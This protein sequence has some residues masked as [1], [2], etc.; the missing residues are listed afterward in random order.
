MLTSEDSAVANSNLAR[1]LDEI[2][3]RLVEARATASPLPG[4]PGPLPEELEHAYSVQSASI[5]RWPD[6]VAGW[7]V[8]GVPPSFRERMGVGRLAGPIF[9]GS[10]ASV[11]SGDEVSMPIFDGGFAAIEAE[12]VFRIGETIEPTQSDLSN[13]E[14]VQRI[15]ALHIGAEVASSPMADINR[16]GPCSIVSDFG[17][18]AGLVVGPEVDDWFGLPP[19]EMS[20]RVTLDGTVV[21]SAD[22][23]AVDG[24]LLQSLRFLVTLC[25]QRDLALP[26]GTLV[27]CGAMTG[28]HEV[29]V[30]SSA[31]I[32]FGASGSFTVNFVAMQ[33][34]R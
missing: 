14:L 9:Q 32:D 5:A 26:S 31:T 13:E 34:R 1:E 12:Y 24:G 33:P 4:F 27:S 15:A 29:S 22:A 3:T 25:A 17:N 10:I 28:I 21:G 16:L 2:S 20:A 6:T 11:Q 8:G 7:K 23:T 19:A 30:G 18:N